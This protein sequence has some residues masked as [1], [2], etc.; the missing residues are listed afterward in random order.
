M[1]GITSSRCRNVINQLAWRV[2]AV[3]AGGASSRLHA[4]MRIRGGRPRCR[5]VA[6]AAGGRRLH[7]C[8]RLGQ[9]I[10]ADERPAMTGLA[11]GGGYTQ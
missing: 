9:C 10:G 6:G 11:I 2:D 1:T 8:C 3:V 5:G 7:V 4:S